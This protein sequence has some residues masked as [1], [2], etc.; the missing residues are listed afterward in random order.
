M[1]TC[2]PNTM[3]KQGSFTCNYY[4]MKRCSC[5]VNWVP[6]VELEMAVHNLGSIFLQVALYR[7]P[8]PEAFFCRLAFA[9]LLL[10]PQGTY[11]TAW[12]LLSHI[13]SA[14]AQRWI[15]L[16]HQMH[17]QQFSCSCW[18][19]HY[20]HAGANAGVSATGS[21]DV[22]SDSDRGMGW[23]TEACLPFCDWDAW[24]HSWWPVRRWK[25]E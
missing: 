6:L 15:T 13:F 9:I 5:S 17:H 18:V 7:K 2:Q 19:F 3:C 8:R 23:T 14:S 16:I 22:N 21:I 10:P 11:C 4:T 20:T 12:N 24:D 1:S 25:T